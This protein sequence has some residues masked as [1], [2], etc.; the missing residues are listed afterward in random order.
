[1]FLSKIADLSQYFE[2]QE[3]NEFESNFFKTPI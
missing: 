1:M 3:K 2:F